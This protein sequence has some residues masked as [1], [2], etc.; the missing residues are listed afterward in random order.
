MKPAEF[1]YHRPKTVTDALGL[2]ATL[3]DDVKLLAGGQSLG[4]MMNLRVARPSHV[5]DIND[6]SDLES[7]NVNG[8][9]IEIGSLVRHHRLATDPQ[10]AAACPILSAAASSIG[11]YAIR[12]RG[13]IGGSLAH[14]DPAAQL[15]LIAVLLDAGIRVG[16]QHGSRTVDAQC[17][18][19]SSL[20]TELAEDELITAIE[21]PVFPSRSGWG[22]E[23]FAQRQGDFAIVSV[24]ATVELSAA[25]VVKS[26]RLAL[27]GTGV[28]P[29]RLPDAEL[30]AVGRVPDHA[31]SEEISRFAA[32]AVTADDDAR[33]P[34]AY[35]RE[36][37]ATLTERA[38]TMAA[39]R[40][41]GVSE[42]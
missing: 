9:R 13:T 28:V 14:A 29:I 4:P 31:L 32:A 33:I 34:V 17:F 16:S 26:L 18:F 19:V 3:G 37:A 40:A 8:D 36:L 2:L 5:I 27:G 20:V 12:Q 7:V 35:R 21:F 1:T 11:H 24:A 6:L 22:I 38:L 30:A 42:R 23:I 25:G 10:I 41:E 15:P 39:Q